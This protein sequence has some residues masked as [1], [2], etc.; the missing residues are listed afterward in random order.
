MQVNQLACTMQTIDGQ[1]Q[2]PALP[3]YRSIPLDAD[4]FRFI[5]INKCLIE[6]VIIHFQVALLA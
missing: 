3:V 4:T 6:M 2:F 5:C 1:S